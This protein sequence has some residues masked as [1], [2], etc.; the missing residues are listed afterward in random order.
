VLCK[1][2][3]E[4]H[5][6]VD[7]P[8]Q[9]DVQPD[10]TVFLFAAL[11][12]IITGILFG[13]WP[14]LRLSR[15]DANAVL[16]GDTGIAIFKKKRRVS[17]RDVLVIG[18]IGL[19]FVI[20]FGSVLSM[21]GL[22]HAVTM[23]IGFQPEGVVTAAFDLGLAGYNEAKGRAFQQRVLEAVQAMPGVTSAA[24]GNSIPLSIDQSTTGVQVAGAPV[25][26]GRNAIAANYYEIS[27]GLLGT[28]GIPLLRGRDFTRYDD[29]RSP[30][31]A[32]VNQTF[33]RVVMR[34][35]DP[36]GKTFRSAYGGP[37]IQVV[38]MLRDGKYQSLTESPR[39]ALFRCSYQSYNPTTTFVV[40]SSLPPGEVV[41]QIRKVI[42][43][44]DP[45]LPV[46]GTGSLT[47]MLGFALFPMHAAAIALSAFG[48][49]AMLLAVTGIHGLVSY[50]VARRT[51]EFGIRIAV[52]APS[53][54]VL[55]LVL[56]RLIS[57]VLT[58]LVIG[59]ALSFV[60]GPVLTNVIYEAS[61]RDPS[62]F[63]AVILLLALAAV[64]SCWS[65]AIRA[66]RT[67]PV[68]ALRYE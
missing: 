37:A 22:Q 15:T 65:P 19:C 57:L 25:Q 29:Q 24:Y 64:L 27:P 46:Y 26:N 35:E 9:F 62:L 52:G 2:L 40:K 8:V 47:K 48:I 30:L 21:R 33:A 31:V 39:P 56:G 50:A 28:L 45:H 20:V 23:Q 4:W 60:A 18:E 11:V 68:T 38:G 58:G 49:L 63:L 44:M 54:A 36:V 16:K 1:L 5:A 3:S 10:W 67:N 43:A 41:E 17:F 59:A 34:T 55:K 7:F 12:A 6:P 61:P 14:A 53:S 51:R 13:L 32:I 42:A 66:L